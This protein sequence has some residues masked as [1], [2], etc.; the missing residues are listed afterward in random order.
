MMQ[1]NE[2]LKDR[3]RALENEYFRRKDRE[4]I[5]ALRE[6]GRQEKERGELKRRL[7]VAD[8]SLPTDLQ[9]AGFTPDNLALLHLVPL[10]D[11]AWAEGGVEA[12]ERQLIVALA[13]RRGVTETSPFTRSSSVGWTNRPAVSSSIPPMTASA[14]CWHNVT[15]RRAR[16]SSTMCWTRRPR[17]PK[18]PAAF[19]A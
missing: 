10:I 18:R 15:A 17:S 19:W 16:P 12:R 13:A 6:Q 14:R 2:W 3:E 4:L 8:D 9:A 1:P 7:G 5:A 11:V